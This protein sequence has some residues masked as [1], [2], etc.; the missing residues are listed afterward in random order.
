L[1]FGIYFSILLAD[2]YTDSDILSVGALFLYYNHATFLF[3]RIILL[4]WVVTLFY[5]SS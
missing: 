1:Y 4:D 3:I 5:P 2:N